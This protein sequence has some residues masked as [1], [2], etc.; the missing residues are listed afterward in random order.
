MA[1]A[2][3]FNEVANFNQFF[4]RNVGITASKFRKPPNYVDVI[5][6]CFGRYTSISNDFESR[7]QQYSD[8]FK[9]G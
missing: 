4:K 9:I 7:N 5:T 2:L 8:V 3:V 1:D 6:E